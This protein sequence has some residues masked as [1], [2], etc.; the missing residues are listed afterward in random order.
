M[1]RARRPITPSLLLAVV[2][3]PSSLL[4]GT[5]ED[6]IDYRQGVMNVFSWNLSHMGSMVKGETAFDAAAFKGHAADLATASTLAVTQG[7]PADSV[8]D[9]SDAKEEIWLNWS[10]FEAKYNALREAAAK[11]SQVAAGGDE[12]AMREQFKE[13]AGACKACHKEYK[14]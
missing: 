9:D 3:F 4:A 10:D 8:S 11:L 7:F 12:G 14:Q 1:C 13:T 5:T 2:A 6:A